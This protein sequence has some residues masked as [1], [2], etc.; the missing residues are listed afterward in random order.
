MKKSERKKR[1]E[2]SRK[3]KKVRWII[4]WNHL[5]GEPRKKK[6]K[7]KGNIDKVTVTARTTVQAL[8]SEVQI[9]TVHLWYTLSQSRA[10]PP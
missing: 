9:H 4:K 8:Q 3:K 7:K 10:S 1:N 5:G 2:K 6:K